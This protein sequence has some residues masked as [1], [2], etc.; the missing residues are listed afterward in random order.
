MW[1]IINIYICAIIMMFGV[2]FF[3]KII[4]NKKIKIAYKSFFLLFLLVCVFHTIIGLNFLGTFKTISM[5]LINTLFLYKTFNI[6]IKKSIFLSFLYMIIL[7]IPDLLQL[8][9]ATSILGISKQFYYE[10]FAGSLISNFIICISCIFI[11]FILR[12]K[13]RK[14]IL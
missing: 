6:Q 8:F 11:T 9:I 14:L 10:E 13:L 1:Q 2:L 12:K 4:L 5:F 3:G 7:M